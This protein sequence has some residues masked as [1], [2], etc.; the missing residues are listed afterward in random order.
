MLKQ[1][2]AYGDEEER[3][4]ADCEKSTDDNETKG[5]NLSFENNDES[6]QQYDFEPNDL[7]D[8]IQLLDS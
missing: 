7:V 1:G 4:L 3:L 2:D 6:N 8:E 5:Q